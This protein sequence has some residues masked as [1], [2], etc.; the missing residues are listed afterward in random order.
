MRFDEGVSLR[1]VKDVNSEV[2][3]LQLLKWLQK[4]FSSMSRFFKENCFF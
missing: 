3:F 1:F 2:I 4:V